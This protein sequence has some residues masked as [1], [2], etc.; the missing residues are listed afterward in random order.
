MMM[1]FVAM[2]DMEAKAC[3]AQRRVCA[4]GTGRVWYDLCYMTFLEILIVIQLSR[5]IG[6]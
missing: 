2:A 1:P 4:R 6:H 5:D 3:D